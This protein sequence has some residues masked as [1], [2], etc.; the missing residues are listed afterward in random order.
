MATILNIEPS[1]IIAGDTWQWDRRDLS[2]YPASSWT[3]KYYLLK[4]DKQIEII[5]SAN[6]DY[7]RVVVAASVTANYPAGIYKWNAYASK[8]TERY[9]VDEGT[10]EI[11]A[12]YAAQTTG[13]DDRSHVKKTL[14]AIEAVIEGR[15]TQDHLS[16]SIAGR[17]ITKISPEELI[18]WWSFYKQQYRKELD[19]ER[20]ANN[21]GTS[22]KI[23]T[24]F[25]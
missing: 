20:I 16:Y 24:R 5:A 25:L 22:K 4:A 3:L 17:S 12:D 15:A 21:L 23:L 1:T 14:D 7:F 8:G 6:G 11:K 18:R 10:L 9:K 19:A 13:Y 2:D